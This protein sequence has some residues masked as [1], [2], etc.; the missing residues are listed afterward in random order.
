MMGVTL[1]VAFGL[2]ALRSY[3]LPDLEHQRWSGRVRRSLE[4]LASKCPPEV[5]RARWDHIVSWTL[6][7]HANCCS[8]RGA[9][10][11]DERGPFADELERRLRGPVDLETIDWIWDE[12]E[13]ISIYGKQ[14]SDCWRPTRP[15]RRGGGG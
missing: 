7:A 3:I 6:N 8:I 12:F 1:G 14:Y 11:A 15:Q 13:R 5:S 4:G 2:A 9:V 10:I